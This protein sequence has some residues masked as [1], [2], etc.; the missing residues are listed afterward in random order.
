ME[1]DYEKIPETH[2]YEIIKLL[3]QGAFGKCPLNLGVVLEAIDTISKR[4]VAWKRLMK[5]SKNMSREI[6]L[7]ELFKD[8]KYI[9]RLE[10]FFF[11]KNIR[12]NIIQNIVLEFGEKDMEALLSEWKAEGVYYRMS[13]IKPLFKAILLGIAE[14]HSKNV[15]HRDLKPYA[16]A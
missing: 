1:I 6:T 8:S 14:L 10:N 15:V 13:K 12:N 4:K 3:G 7:L 9:I 2:Q 16:I 11:S 5:K